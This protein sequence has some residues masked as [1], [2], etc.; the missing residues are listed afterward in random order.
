LKTGHT[1]EQASAILLNDT[2]LSEWQIDF[3]AVALDEVAE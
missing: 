2:G 1:T 3:L